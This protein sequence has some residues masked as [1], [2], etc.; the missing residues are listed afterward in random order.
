MCVLRVLALAAVAIAQITPSPS[1]LAALTTAF[2]TSQHALPD[3]PFYNVPANFTS[4]MA[5]GSL[6]NIEVATNLTNYTVP[7]SLSMSRIIYTTTDVHGT[8]LPASA[9]ILWP[10]NSLPLNDT[11][12]YTAVAWAHGTSG[13]HAPCGPSS[14]RSLQY[15][16]MTPYLLAMQGNVVI[17]ADYAGLG[18]GYL[19]NGD[20]IPHP[21]NTSPAQAN[22]V[23]W[24]IIAAR[25]AF[26]RQLAADGPFV[27]MRHSQGGRAAWAFAERQSVDPV[28]GYRGT[29]AFT[30][31]P[32]SI[33]QWEQALQYPQARWAHTTFALAALE[34]DATTAVYPSYAH[35]GF[36]PLAAQRFLDT[37]EKS[38]G[39]LPTASVLFSTLPQD[40]IAVANWTSDPD[41]RRWQNLTRVGRKK[42]AGPL[43]LLQGASDSYSPYNESI[44]SSLLTTVQ[45]TCD[46]LQREHWAESL[47]FVA[48]SGMDHFPIIQASQTKWLPWIKDRFSAQAPSLGSG[49][50]ISEVSGFR[51]EY[52]I[53]GPQPNFLV[54]WADKMD[55]WEYTL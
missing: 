28:P 48:Y 33:A 1:Q 17:A 44:S 42:F 15:H 55:S 54:E 41:V 26:P 12:G 32:D 9:Y 6:L 10:Y 25:K 38:Q 27:T 24:A 47:E 23:A 3:D 7:A 20:R 45:D 19:P 51:T 13:T 39:C 11:Q 35:K 43:L 18:V 8:I 53:P 4:S 16:F 14:Y 46:C 34:I 2:E 50:A 22:D 37:Y 40:S 31:P 49:C 36:T 29:V 5:P 30:P 52:T 21:H